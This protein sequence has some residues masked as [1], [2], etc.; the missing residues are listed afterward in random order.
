MGF[1]FVAVESYG[2]VGVIQITRP[3][4]IVLC[5]VGAVSFPSCG[6]DKSTNPSPPTTL[7]PAPAPS[8]TPTPT[9]GSVTPNSCSGPLPAPGPCGVRPDPQLRSALAQAE[10]EVKR[11]KDLFYPDG[12]TIRYLSRYRAALV[13]ALDARGLCGVWDYGNAIGDNLYLRTADG[14]ISEGYDAITG[15]GQPGLVYANSC[16]PASTPPGPAP[17]YGASADPTCKLG[18]SGE[19]FCLSG[20]WGTDYASDVRSAITSVIAEKPDLFDL[21]DTLNSELSYKLNDPAAYVAAV[22]DKL[23]AKGYC[24]VEHEELAVKLDNTVSENYDIVR[25][26]GDRP[27]QYSLFAPKGRCHNATF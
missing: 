4:A 17:Q 24:A 13:A 22:L 19:T 26:P 14:R 3:V 21:K 7:S 12:V 5:V 9:P 10:E 1:I 20:A 27:S 8:P 23:R 25:S 6:G 16:E 11:Q 15:R 2:E 18:G